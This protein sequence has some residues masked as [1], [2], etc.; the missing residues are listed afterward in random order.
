MNRLDELYFL[1]CNDSASKNFLIHE[2]INL[3]KRIAK[4]KIAKLMIYNV[5]YEDIEDYVLYIANKILI[6]YT[7]DKGLFSDY[8]SYVFGKR[9]TTKIVNLCQTY[10]KKLASLDAVLEDGTPLIEMVQDSKYPSIAEEISLNEL[11]SLMSSPNVK[12][13]KVEKLAKKVYEH[14]NA[15]YLPSEIM[16]K[17]KL[18]KG[19][20]RYIRA[21]IAKEISDYKNRLELK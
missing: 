11:K 14:I 21:L 15:G 1:A 16:Q 13:S 7:N 5:Q 2:L 8:A 18:S 9:I 10:G 19:Q 12:N 3:G 20:Y 17:F 6:N 4:Q